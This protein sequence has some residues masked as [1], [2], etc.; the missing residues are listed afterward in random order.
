MHLVI[1]RDFL[2][3]TIR[4]WTNN[5]LCFNILGL[6]KEIRE[7]NC[8]TH[9]LIGWTTDHWIRW[10]CGWNKLQPCS[11]KEIFMAKT[12]SLLQ[13]EGRISN[14]IERNFGLLSLYNF[15]FSHFFQVYFNLAQ[16]I[17]QFFIACVVFQVVLYSRA[18][19][20]MSM[21]ALTQP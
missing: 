14:A 16:K 13:F 4:V 11:L 20:C 3:S 2:V 12:L 7:M 19:K 8:V 1:K 5:T 10:I 15:A 9:T 6:I 17:K 21:L 18:V